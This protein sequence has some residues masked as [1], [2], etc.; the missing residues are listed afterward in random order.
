ME[1]VIEQLSEYEL[2]RGKPVPDT[3]HGIVQTNI[4]GELFIRYRSVYRIMSEVTLDTQPVGTTPDVLVYPTFEPDF[5]NRSARRSDPPLL[6]IEIQSP[7]QS[8]E[9]MVE[10]TAI[11]FHFGVKSCWVVLPSIKAVIVYTAP[12]TYRFFHDKD[13]LTDENAGIELPV[14]LLFA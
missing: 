7:S 1:S 4:A 10:K 6:T 8:L 11:Y 5:Q 9:V 3:I 14:D 2:E 13:L 12:D